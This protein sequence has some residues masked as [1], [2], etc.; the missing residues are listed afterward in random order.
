MSDTPETSEPPAGMDWET[1]YSH[2]NR[3]DEIRVQQSSAFDK[4]ILTLSSGGLAFSLV[5]LQSIRDPKS[6]VDNQF[7]VWSWIL[8]V[9]A[10]LMNVLSYYVS[11]KAAEVAI[12]HMDRR[13]KEQDWEGT[14]SNFRDKLT[15]ILNSASGILFA[16]GAVCLLVFA[17]QNGMGP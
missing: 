17:Y 4:S 8:F 9:A 15:R 10:I 14:D 3:L 11:S 16:T 2:R 7:L 5:V 13:M 6:I 12:A 1:Y